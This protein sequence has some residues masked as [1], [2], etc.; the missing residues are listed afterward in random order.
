[1][2][3]VREIKKHCPLSH[4]RLS[5]SGGSVLFSPVPKKKESHPL[6]MQTRLEF[7]KRRVIILL[8]LVC[9]FQ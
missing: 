8:F 4:L 6:S 5:F 3:R 9:D 1:M 2:Y 7:S